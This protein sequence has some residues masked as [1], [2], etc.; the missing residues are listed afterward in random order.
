MGCWSALLSINIFEERPSGASRASRP[1]TQD[2]G[3]RAVA[4]AAFGLLFPIIGH[5]LL[6]TELHLAFSNYTWHF[7][8]QNP[9]QQCPNKALCVEIPSQMSPKSTPKGPPKNYRKI[10]TQNFSFLMEKK[11]HTKAMQPR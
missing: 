4:L 8:R 5:P 7:W 9:A 1:D 10:D 2:Y 3:N 6:T 11:Q